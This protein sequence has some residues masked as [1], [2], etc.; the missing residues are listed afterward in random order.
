MALDADP[1][2]EAPDYWIVAI[3]EL[4]KQFAEWKKYFEAENYSNAKTAY[5]KVLRASPNGRS[6][7][8]DQIRA[9][10]Q[11]VLDRDLQQ[12]KEACNR[13]D[14]I[15]TDSLR[16]HARAV[17]PTG[18]LN[19]DTLDQMRSC[20]SGTCVEMPGEELIKAKALRY[21]PDPDVPVSQRPASPLVVKLKIDERG[22]TTL[23]DLDNPEGNVQVSQAVRNAVQL[24]EWNPK[25]AG[26]SAGKCAATT[27]LIELPR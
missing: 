10:Y 3:A 7:A 23:L 12:W 16:R 24:W 9:R 8:L 4:Q 18:K 19:K 15:M 14:V 5:D 21:R 27:L 11:N 22:A 25:T 6:A 13:R 20:P 17:D 26:A 2:N 1:A